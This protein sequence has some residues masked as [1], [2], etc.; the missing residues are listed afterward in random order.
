MDVLNFCLYFFPGDRYDEDVRPNQG[1]TSS[2]QIGRL[3][4]ID[5]WDRGK[6]SVASEAIDK[7]KDLWY[8]AHGKKNIDD[9]IDYR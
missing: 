4:D 9:V 2:S 6:K 1:S 7:V 3:D 8:R 5:E